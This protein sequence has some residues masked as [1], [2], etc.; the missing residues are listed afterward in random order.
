MGRKLRTVHETMLPKKIR[1]D[2]KRENKKN[3]CAVITPVYARDYRLGRQ[4]TAVII[5]NSHGSMIY[6]VDV[7]KDTNLLVSRSIRPRRPMS[8][9]PKKEDVRRNDNYF[10]PLPIFLL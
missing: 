2:K 3:V 5:T 8:D 4:W 9:L 1:P 6:D 10:P 7:G